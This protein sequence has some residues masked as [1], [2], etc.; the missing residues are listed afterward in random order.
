MQH[1]AC[2]QGWMLLGALCWS[3]AWGTV[4]QQEETFPICPI[5]GIL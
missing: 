4:R 2:T 1:P 3:G 5:P